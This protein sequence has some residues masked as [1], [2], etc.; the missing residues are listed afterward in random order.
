MKKIFLSLSLACA[1]V[2]LGGCEKD[3]DQTP[4]SNGSVPD[5]YK[6][7]ADFDQAMT[8]VY[9]SL[10][11]FP[12]REVILSELRSDNMF[13][14]SSIGSRDWDPVNN[15]SAALLVVNPYV[16]DAWASDYSTIFR[17]NTMLDQLDKNGAAAGSLRAR[18]EGEAKFIRAFMYLDLVRKFGRVPVID[19]PLIPQEVAKK[20][21]NEVSEVY[22][23]IESD[24]RTAIANLP[25]S[26][27]GT[28]VGATSGVGRVTNGAAKGMLALM[29]LTKS[30]PDYGIKGPGLNS[31][32]YDKA[33]VL[34]D[35]I[36]N[37]TGTPQS[38]AYSLQTNYANIFSP[39]NENNSEVLFDIQ[40]ISNGLGTL[41][42]SFMNVVVPDAYYQGLATNGNLALPFSAGS[43]EIKPVS[44]DLNNVS[45]AATDT[46]RA[47]TIQQGYTNAGTTD[48]RPF[49]KKYVNVAGKG[50]SRTDWATNYIVLR[51]TDIL[52]MKAECEVRGIGGS[53]ATAAARLTPIRTRAG[54]PAFTTIDLPGLMEERRREFAGENLRWND[55]MR[56]GLALTT[57]NAWAN[58]EDPTT[59]PSGAPRDYK[60]VRP[61]TKDLLLLP[62]PQVELGS[63]PGTY[64]QNDGY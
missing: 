39:T 28:G 3:L 2:S 4:I 51:Y 9:S 27:T 29:Y 31:N 14:V 17:A 15:F 1:L 6:T 60:I 33:N 35:E 61:I 5:F 52:M 19:K 43:V 55:L 18:Y 41:G 26:Y 25:A 40:Y 20:G 32:E 23:L 49:Y 36:I 48:T 63:A 45:Y 47:A 8:S 24:L 44:N 56:S 62:V 30:G 12:D 53:P 64:T 57:M 50:T 13:A 58:R 22:A 46:R 7:A 10:R 34:L 11:G 16:A 59:L 42:S 37:R 38:A 54:Q 21:R